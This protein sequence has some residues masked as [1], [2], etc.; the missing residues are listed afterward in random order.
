M[1][2]SSLLLS[3]PE[4]FCRISCRDGDV[5]HVWLHRFDT[6]KVNFKFYLILIKPGTSGSHL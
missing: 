2:L 3:R 1:N 6:E 5:S 4:M